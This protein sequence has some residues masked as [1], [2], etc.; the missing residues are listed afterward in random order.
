MV[1]NEFLPIDELKKLIV[2]KQKNGEGWPT[3]LLNVA[4]SSEYRPD[5]DGTLSIFMNL[6]GKSQCAVNNH[7]ATIDSDHFF[8]SN[9]S[10]QYTLTVDELTPAETFNIHFGKALIHETYNGLITAEDRLLD[11]NEQSTISPSFYNKLYRKDDELKKLMARIKTAHREETYPQ[12]ELEAH[13]QDVLIYLLQQHRGT[14]RETKKVPSAKSST[15]LEI[16]RRLSISIDYMHSNIGNELALDTLAQV[17]MLSKFHYLRLFK[18]VFQC[19]P[20]QYISRIRIEKAKNLL[21]KT[22]F[23]VREIACLVGLQNPSSFGRLFQ[24]LTNYTPMAY[25]TTA[26]A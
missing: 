2:K 17:A 15:Q 11:N 18:K 19:T 16:Y 4:T 7:T 24:K 25:R 23:N 22:N 3:C 8:V 6:Q 21:H 1:R 20:H 13:L 10:Q 5:V 14:L 9:Q 12:M 26:Q